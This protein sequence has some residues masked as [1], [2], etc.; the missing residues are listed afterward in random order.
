MS[1]GSAPAPRR[2]GGLIFDFDGLIL[3]TETP[4][5]DV[6]CAIYRE[7][8]CELP[9]AV[10]GECV[11]TAAGTFDPCAYLEARCSR[12]VDRAAI[13][14]DRQ[15]RWGKL[16]AA[17]GALPGVERYL[18]D[19]ARLGLAVGLASSSSRDW[20]TGHLRRLG[21]LRYFGNLQC[22][23]DVARVKPAPDL[24]L[25]AVAALG[26]EPGE[27]IAFEDSPHGVTAA[28]R[29]GL[30]CVA[31]PNA[32]TRHLPLDHADLRL[33]SLASLPLTSLIEHVWSTPSAVLH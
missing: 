30:Y 6:W 19:A 11:G 25:A 14:T 24:Y 1:S 29:A 5:Y 23:E 13:E 20:V 17:Q 7:H 27:A 16:I 9:L 18:E 2:T 22:R 32:L 4:E 12:P 33:E 8:G 28:Q 21:L 10:W 26:I 15:R 3:D 31:V